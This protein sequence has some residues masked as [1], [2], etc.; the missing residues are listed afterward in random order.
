MSVIQS[1]RSWRS[2]T[3]EH[4]VRVVG[5]VDADRGD[6]RILALGSWC[7]Y[8]SLSMIFPWSISEI[9]A[10]ALWHRRHTAYIKT[11]DRSGQIW[12]DTN[13]YKMQISGR[14]WYHWYLL[15]VHHIKPVP[16]GCCLALEPSFSRSF[17]PW[18]W[19]S[20]TCWWVEAVT[21]SFQDDLRQL[22]P[23]FSLRIWTLY[24]S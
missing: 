23:V 1:W 11:Q 21:G 19:P 14:F 5:E 4:P 24:T 20:G 9:L 22:L 18:R 15:S 6:V 7:S 10:L 8:F 3:A 12:D 2:V 17:W 16:V 13:I